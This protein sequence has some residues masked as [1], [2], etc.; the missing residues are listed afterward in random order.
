MLCWGKRPRRRGHSRAFPPGVVED[1]PG[2]FG[3][4]ALNLPGIVHV[5]RL[6]AGQHHRDG[7]AVP[8]GGY[9]VNVNDT[10]Q[11]QSNTAKVARKVLDHAGWKRAA[12]PSS[13]GSFPPAEH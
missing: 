1:L 13:P 5:D 4:V 2:D 8:A 11:I 7:H 10:V 9:S 6:P 12:M 3:R